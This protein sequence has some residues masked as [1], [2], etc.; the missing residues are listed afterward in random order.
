MAQGAKI[1]TALP[2]FVPVEPIYPSYAQEDKGFGMRQQPLAL[3]LPQLCS[4]TR[5]CSESTPEENPEE[6]AE[7]DIEAMMRRRRSTQLLRLMRLNSMHHHQDTSFAFT[8]TDSREDRPEVTLPP[9]KRLGISLGLAYEVGESLSAAAARPAGGLRADYGRS[10][11]L[12]DH[13]RIEVMSL[14]TTVLAQQ[15]Q[16]R[17]LQSTDCRRQTVITESWQSRSQ[18]GKKQIS[19]ALSWVGALDKETSD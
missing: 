9:R 6:D 15:S 1:N 11:D 13:A 5:L 2:D 12:S 4:V 18:E 19:K 8:P 17:E 14:R 3:L 7:V 16:I 10:M